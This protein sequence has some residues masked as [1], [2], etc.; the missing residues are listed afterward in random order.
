[1]GVTNIAMAMIGGP[2]DHI[3]DERFRVRISAIVDARF[4]MM[5]D[6]A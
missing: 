6:G 5:M 1:M 2:M 3:K 4:R